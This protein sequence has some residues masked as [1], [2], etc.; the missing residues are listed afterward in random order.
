MLIFELSTILIVS[1]AA[2]LLSH[3]G[4]FI[5]G[6]H[7]MQAPA[8]GTLYAL[9]SIAIYSFET[10][11]C[12]APCPN[13]FINTLKIILAYIVPLFTSIAI[14]RCF[15]HRLHSFPGPRI[16][17]V[18][19][20]WH[21]WQCITSRNHLLMEKLNRQYGAIVRTGEFGQV[22]LFLQSEFNS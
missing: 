11:Q 3:W 5:R 14:Y 21:S 6:E 18:S 20:L 7:H 22:I 15:F 12:Q 2:G 16:A 19:K 4:Y 1:S 13:P 17:R 8:L 9:A 10:S